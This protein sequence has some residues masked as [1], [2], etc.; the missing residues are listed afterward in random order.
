MSSVRMQDDSRQPGKKIAGQA[1]ICASK[2]Y[3]VKTLGFKDTSSVGTSATI[4]RHLSAVGVSTF[5][6]PSHPWYLTGKRPLL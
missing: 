2:V 6:L 3:E 1:T 5:Q 4:Q